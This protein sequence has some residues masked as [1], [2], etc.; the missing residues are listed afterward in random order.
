M[1]DPKL[2]PLPE[3]VRY[4]DAN[5]L[6]IDAWGI[7]CYRAGQKDAKKYKILIKELVTA[8]KETNA[9]LDWYRSD[10]EDLIE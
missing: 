8:L 1:T 7:A 5:Y 3:S 2:P 4:S 6:H 9:L 10:D